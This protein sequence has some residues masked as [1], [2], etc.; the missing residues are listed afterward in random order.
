M[1]TGR[2]QR[3]PARYEDLLKVPDNLVAEIL[4]GE[5]YTSPRPRGP[6][7]TASSALGA[8]LVPPYW[9]RC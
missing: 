2:A 9:F 1:P 5:L 6:H 4:G 7:G 3:R 8:V